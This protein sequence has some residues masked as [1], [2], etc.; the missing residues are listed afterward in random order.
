MDWQKIETY[1]RVSAYLPSAE[2]CAHMDQEGLC[3]K[4]APSDL[5]DEQWAI[6]SPMMPPAKQHPRGGRPRKVARR[7]V[8][9]TLWS[10]HRRGGPWDRLP[11]AFLPK[12]TVDDYVSQ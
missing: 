7:E 1:E 8:R 11:H 3:R 6:V 2:A 5:T 10:L 12:R 9:N 4:T